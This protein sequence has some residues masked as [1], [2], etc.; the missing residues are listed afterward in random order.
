MAL[1]SAALAAL[2]IACAVA[3]APRPQP[4]P[5]PASQQPQP[6]QARA[7]GAG[8][9]CACA[10]GEPSSWARMNA[11]DLRRRYGGG[12]FPLHAAVADADFP[13]GA[14]AAGPRA[15]RGAG[16]SPSS[17]GARPPGPPA[18]LPFWPHRSRRSPAHVPDAHP[19]A[20]PPAHT[21]TEQEVK[22]LLAS[23]ADPNRRDDRGYTPLHVA[24]LTTS[25]PYWHPY[26]NATATAIRML[27]N[28]GAD[29]ATPLPKG[30]FSDGTITP[31]HWV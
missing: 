12:K 28:A 27:L 4:Q 31:L 15:T 11:E 26:S 9:G 7:P 30:D 22:K 3:Q 2:L 20:P 17:S 8:A 16:G 6:P 19:P 14:V 29:P 10:K 23:G 21:C 1:Q 24:L 25:D 18:L 5:Q 13:V